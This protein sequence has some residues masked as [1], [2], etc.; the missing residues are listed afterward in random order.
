M[1]HPRQPEDS[2]VLRGPGTGKGW[3]D[4]WDLPCTQAALP[5]YQ[6]GPFS[7]GQ[8]FWYLKQSQ[9]K[10]CWDLCPLFPAARSLGSKASVS[11]CRVGVSYTSWVSGLGF[12]TSLWGGGRVG[13]GG[14]R[15]GATPPLPPSHSTPLTQ[16]SWCSMIPSMSGPPTSQ[17]SWCGRRTRPSSDQ[18]P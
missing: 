7:S 18:G 3:A 4:G 2:R 15:V 17:A 13:W 9:A 16:T 8:A 5:S 12:P 14:V 1:G 6:P 11:L 10:D